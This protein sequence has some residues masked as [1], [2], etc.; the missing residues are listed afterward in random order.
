MSS[1]W[2]ASIST[3]LS[4]TKKFQVGTSGFDCNWGLVT[5]VVDV[6]GLLAPLS[7]SPVGFHFHLLCSWNSLMDRGAFI[8]VLAVSPL[9]VPSLRT[10]IEL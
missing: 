8:V 3:D 6:V 4:G 10:A 5:P 7:T 1:P 9:A 2:S